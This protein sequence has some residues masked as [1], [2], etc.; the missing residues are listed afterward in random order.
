MADAESAVPACT[1]KDGCKPMQWPEVDFPELLHHVA[2]VH[3][4]AMHHIA[5]QNEALSA[6]LSEL[7]KASV[8][9][10]FA[11][12]LQEQAL[13]ADASLGESDT[14][15]ARPWKL[16]KF[17]VEPEHAMMGQEK[18]FMPT[19]HDPRHPP[20]S[21]DGTPINKT[22]TG[23]STTN[24]CARKST[25]K[26]ILH[27]TSMPAQMPSSQ[28]E[29]GPDGKVRN[30]TGVSQVSDRFFN[31]IRSVKRRTHGSTGTK[32]HTPAEMRVSWSGIATSRYRLFTKRLQV[33]VQSSLFDLL[34]TIVIITN[35]VNVG[36]EVHKQAVGDKV[37]EA[38][39]YIDVVTVL[40]YSIELILR[41]WADGFRRNRFWNIFDFIM[42]VVGV[43]D[44]TVDMDT[45]PRNYSIVRFLRFVRVFRV[46]KM[47]KIGKTVNAYFLV[48]SKMTY[49]L[50]HSV[51]SLLSAATVIM[52]FTYICAIILTQAVTDYRDTLQVENLDLRVDYGS[53]DRTFYSLT[54]ATFNGQAWGELMQ[55][56]T[57]VSFF[58]TFVFLM[59]LMV[60]LLCFLNV[61]HGVFVDSALQ[62]TA[63]YKEIMVAE[64][65]QKRVMMSQHLQ[66][67]FHEIDTDKSG[68]I[69]VQEFAAC[70]ETPG[71]RAFFE[72]MGL[73]TVEAYDLFRLID[74]D[75]SET[76]DIEEFCQGCLRVMGEAK[77]F[78]IQLIIAE[79][80]QVLEKWMSFVHSFDTT[81]KPLILK[82][83]Q[84]QEAAPALASP[85]GSAG[86]NKLVKD[87][88]AGLD[89]T[90]T[91]GSQ[92]DA[93]SKSGSQY[94]P[95]FSN[96]LAAA[97]GTS[98]CYEPFFSGS[99]AS[100]EASFGPGS[101]M[102]PRK[103]EVVEE[104]AQKEAL[105]MEE[106]PSM[107]VEACEH[108]VQ[109][110]AERRR[111]EL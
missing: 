20:E 78:D 73:S 25:Q 39:H 45:M 96:G 31:A 10:S 36:Y 51:P 40:W 34:C 99:A 63:H 49:C 62:S 53:L 75:A 105:H 11:D 98:L 71:G 88:A 80:R 46:L 24:S 69:T 8:A 5:R 13:E 41:L 57:F 3:A 85:Q 28:S 97:G 7:R 35:A 86:V 79:N 107:R 111:C 52:I 104:V 48:F 108:P 109:M 22:F 16:P 23:L 19:I 95:Q 103:P 94:V 91:N 92:L 42:L 106:M 44:L 21:V 110:R 32:A 74:D 81:I 4:E 82:A 12:G 6:E 26:S 55:P 90:P 43:L 56:L 84:T 58:S 47:L 50:L 54:K 29:G 27:A 70:L 93:D 14:E 61:I 30:P 2:A 1:G 100:A 67:V 83:L 37:P 59:Y 102:Q 60:I 33:V 17:I 9:Q 87:F 77:N 15:V 18:I 89:A 64:V 101:S 38:S 66:D 72:V 68:Y 65:Q 76:V